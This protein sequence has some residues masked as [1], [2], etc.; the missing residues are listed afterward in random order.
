MM[1]F[2]CNTMQKILAS[3]DLDLYEA[4]VIVDVLTNPPAAEKSLNFLGRYKVVL[5]QS[6]LNSVLQQFV[7][8]ALVKEATP[9]FLYNNGSPFFLLQF[10]SH[11]PTFGKTLNTSSSSKVNILLYCF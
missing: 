9:L 1:Q 3:G 8:I 10:P 11:Q 7:E 5:G 6:L 4:A 2:E